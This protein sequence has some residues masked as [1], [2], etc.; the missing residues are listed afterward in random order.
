MN[1]TKNTRTKILC[2]FIAMV[3]F[4][5]TAWWILK[6]KENAH[7][8]ILKWMPNHGHQNY[9]ILH[10]E[11][12]EIITNANP[13]YSFY[14]HKDSGGNIT[15][16]TVK[17]SSAVVP[18]DP[19]DIDEM[20]D[21]INHV[22]SEARKTNANASKI[23]PKLK[24][25]LTFNPNKDHAVIQ[26]FEKRGDFRNRPKGTFVTT[27]DWKGAE[28]QSYKTFAPPLLHVGSLKIE[29]PVSNFVCVLSVPLSKAIPGTAI[30]LV[31]KN[32]T[33]NE[34]LDSLSAAISD[35]FRMNPQ[36]LSH[37]RSFEDPDLDLIPKGNFDVSEDGMS[38][39]IRVEKFQH[40]RDL[41]DQANLK[42]YCKEKILQGSYPFS[43]YIQPVKTEP[44]E[45]RWIQQAIRNPNWKN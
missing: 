2:F 30:G 42:Q 12:N 10:S 4:F 11:L 21:M 44:T 32:N 26:R 40:N 41:A 16:L 8:I 17:S 9:E 23:L 25:T 15:G 20:I 24:M 13:N 7:A 19:F 36:H 27:L 14:Y 34:N 31:R 3:G 28:I 39:L 6:E 18:L 5:L 35:A 29:D 22:A 38:L 37:T 33:G 43:K 1:K 45:I